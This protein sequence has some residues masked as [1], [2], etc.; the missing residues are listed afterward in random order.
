MDETSGARSAQGP[1]VHSA[2]VAASV[3]V[4]VAL[5]TVLGGLIPLPFGDNPHS[6][7]LAPPAAS[8][9]PSGSVAI[10]PGFRV[11]PG[12]VPLGSVGRDVPLRVAVGF[13][14]AD[15]AALSAQ[16]S[17]EYGPGSPLYH[18]YLSADD[19][20]LRYGSSP[21]AYA[22]AESY[23]RSFGL[24]VQ[25]SPDRLLLLASGPAASVAAAFHTQ[26]ELYR[27]DGRVFYSHPSAATLPR[28]APW[29][30]AL[31]LGNLTPLVP[32]VRW[33]PGAAGPTDPSAAT[34]SVGPCALLGFGYSPCNI[35]GAY[36][37]T[38]LLNAGTNGTGFRIGIVDTYDS[39]E[40]QTQLARDFTKFTANFSLPS[41]NVRWVYPIPGVSTL[42][43]TPNP[44]WGVEEALDLQWARASA[45]GAG[46]D[47]TFAPDAFSGLYYSVDYLVAHHLVDVIS[48]SWGEPDTG[49]FNAGSMPCAFAC[50]ATSDGTYTL[51]HP[52]LEAA[53]AEG[54]GVF[55]ASGDC[56]AADGTSGVATNYPASDD[57]VTGVGGTVLNVSASNRYAGE[58][59]WF[60]N[61]SGASPPGCVNQGG[62]GG[63]FAP[64]ARPWW[65]SGPGIG[66]SMAH[67][68]V[69]DVSMVAG[70][71]VVIFYG[72]SPVAVGGTSAATPMW[73]GLAAIADTVA[74]G[75]LGWLDPALYR[76]LRSGG[77]ASAFHDITD[78]NNGYSAGVGWDPVSGIGTPNA[79]NLV[80]LLVSPPP[81][82]PT[83]W[84]TLHATPRFVPVGGTVSFAV[85][86]T[87]GATPYA[88]EDV[89][90]GDGN[91]TPATNGTVAHAFT[92]AGVY[93]AQAVV[94]DAAGNTSVSPPLA[95]VVG[96][97]GSLQINFTTSASSPGVGTPVW[98]NA[99]ASG[100]RGPYSYRFSFGDGTYSL[101]SPSARVLHSFGAPGGYCAAVTVV[102]NDTP[103][104]GGTSIRIPLAVGGAPAPP[105]ED[106][107]PLNVTVTAPLRA[108]DV[109]GDFP[110]STGLTGG[111]PPVSLQYTSDDPYVAAC[112]C[113][114]FHTPGN[115]SLTIFA[116]DSL[117]QQVVVAA[118]SFTLYPALVG[119][120]HAS[121]LTG[122]APLTITFTANGSGGHLPNAAGTAWT[123][124]DGTAG[125]GA[126]VVHTYTTPGY[127]L[128]VG[129]LSD[130]GF[131]N[132]S[133][134]FVVDVTA[135]PPPA[136]QI[137]VGATIAP[138]RNALAGAPVYFNASASGGTGPY[139]VR[140]TFGPN[141]SAFG[142][143]VVQSFPTGT[144]LANGTCSLRVGLTVLDST[145][146]F[147]NTSFAL[148]SLLARR[149]SAL[150]F[151]STLTPSG[152]ATPLPVTGR[153]SVA[154]VLGA[155]IL[156]SFGDGASLTGTAVQHRYLT[157]GNYT[158]YANAT[159][160]GGD[161]LVRSVT[162]AVT[163]LART[164]PAIGGGP[165]TTWGIV[166]FLVEFQVNG[167]GGAGPPYNF[168]LD[169]G[170]GT[171]AT[172][173]QA[174]HVYDRPG[175]Y[176]A[177]V[178]VTD[179]VG[180]TSATVYPVRA[181]N[182]TSVALAAAL[183][184]GSAIGGSPVGLVSRASPLCR[185][186]SVPDCGPAAVTIALAWMPASGSGSVPTL[187][188]LAADGGGWAN[189]TLPTPS[190]PGLYLLSLHAVGPNYTGSAVAWLTV[191]A[192]TNTLVGPGL[193]APVIVAASLLVGVVVAGIALGR[194]RGYRRVR[195]T[196]ATDEAA[197]D[198]LSP[199]PRP[200][201]EGGPPDG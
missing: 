201:E 127:Y 197:P 141:E 170:D 59:G 108:A 187:P 6:S 166:P 85:A 58:I 52:V 147:T 181:Y 96:G 54:I 189:A 47:M 139:L 110:I 62:S 18:H 173:S 120:F 86:A 159:D 67:R 148:G 77:Y 130:A 133:E 179:A 119:R 123:F 101:R 117:D 132:A 129:D 83:A 48:L 115:H 28:I 135:G 160:L 195:I 80:S 73:A 182:A 162:V 42:N 21:S 8:A 124:G 38:P 25:P 97:G 174:S 91:A 134:A 185:P 55:A 143:S 3:G 40:P 70:N 106:P 10:A 45:P 71:G 30:G 151:S 126:A 125:V 35:S 49:V 168:T 75:P 94:F 14:P 74:G 32:A 90:F 152:G 140:W 23:F 13:A 44:G 72:S 17:A 176:N 200:S 34:P 171:H 69:P 84:A 65:Q 177:T 51:L 178:F 22:A 116:N 121:S 192:G 92:R 99:T 156:W 138:A 144:C 196:G 142:A 193:P 100:G 46:I 128:A 57:S 26:F 137:V 172:G 198:G 102:D 164:L 79:A 186:T 15:P 180:D 19:V 95:I 163:G 4:A 37:F 66:A 93:A 20:S 161:R 199:S 104:D 60:G 76:V 149:W 82:V 11:S 29:T 146:D 190:A 43:S 118:P 103:A 7:P 158:A 2:R 12:V 41:G 122:P 167:T 111:T 27:D 155:T 9:A 131:G 114:I 157:P 68:G 183:S 16:L 1:R 150:T 56:G 88:L 165:S 53:A 169:F 107:A 194:G 136:G 154:G 33:A 81:I 175:I 89:T 188:S 39:E 78:G 145:G 153:G 109:P 50:N 105:C 36:N 5:L 31:G 61:A 87:G 112:S 24:Q 184:A 191:K 113:A 64:W 63:G 98:F